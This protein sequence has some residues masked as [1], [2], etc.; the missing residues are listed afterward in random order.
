M[1]C[2]HH[3][4]F[5]PTLKTEDAFYSEML[6]LLTQYLLSTNRSIIERSI[7]SDIE[8]EVNYHKNNYSNEVCNEPLY[9]WLNELHGAE[10]FLRS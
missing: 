3:Q 1:T 8:G 7:I 2:L 10:S 4:G 5:K 9:C 6:A